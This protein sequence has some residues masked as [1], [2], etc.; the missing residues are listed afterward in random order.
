MKKNT[1]VDIL[2]LS[3]EKELSNLPLTNLSYFND[4]EHI[5]HGLDAEGILSI[6]KV[7]ISL[8]ITSQREIYL[9]F[10]KLLFLDGEKILILSYTSEEGSFIKKNYL[11]PFSTVIT[12]DKKAIPS[13]ISVYPLHLYPYLTSD[14]I[15]Y[16]HTHYAAAVT[17]NDKFDNITETMG[18]F[19]PDEE[20]L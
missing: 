17:L 3:E 20:S 12:L 1:T 11:L 6:A 15:V 9:P 13:I 16:I 10:Q 5:H 18:Y 14:G 7:E 4:R 8:S 19:N 2:G